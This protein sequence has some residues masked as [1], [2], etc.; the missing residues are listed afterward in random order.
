MDH[1]NLLVHLLMDVL[2]ISTFI[3]WILKGTPFSGDIRG[4][5]GYQTLL[6]LAQTLFLKKLFIYL[7]VLDLSCGTWDS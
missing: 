7:A 1:I 6:R 4:T 3:V 2:V 5:D